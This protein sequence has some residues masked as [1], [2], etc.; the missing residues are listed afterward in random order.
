M[1]RRITSSK[2]TVFNILKSSGVALSQD[3]IE[4]KVAGEM[5][6]ATMYRIL[7]SFCEDGHVHRIFSDDGRTYFA[8]CLNCKENE[9]HHN[10][11]HFRCLKCLRMEC[12]KEE[13]EITMPQGYIFKDANCLVT[14]YCNRCS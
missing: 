9:H 1:K 10:H 4:N 7:N 5:N 6:R 2:Q 8:V 14:G 13:I 11:V 3:D 12:L